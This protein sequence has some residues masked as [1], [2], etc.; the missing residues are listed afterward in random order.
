MS[1]TIEGF[2]TSIAGTKISP[3]VIFDIGAFHGEWSFMASKIL[4][5]DSLFFLFEPN[6]EHNAHLVR[7]GFK[8]FNTLLGSVTR[9]SVK[10]WAVGNTGDSI[11][12]EINESYS[13]VE[14]KKIKMWALDQFI[15]DQGLPLPDLMKVDTQGAELD[16]LRGAEIVLSNL[17][18]LVLELPISR[19]NLEAP[20]ISEILTFLDHLKFVPVAVTEVH[21]I[22]STL[23][24]IDM[25]FLSHNAFIELHGHKNK[26]FYS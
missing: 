23:V 5:H 10:F 4:E 24:Q 6:D 9:E 21:K 11:Y 19:L 13:E 25:A 20:K 17:K 3:K 22:N 15:Q 7:R 2:L 18:I 16:I 14:P 26:Y 1:P 12:K 8:F